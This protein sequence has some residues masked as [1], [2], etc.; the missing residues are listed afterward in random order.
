[1]KARALTG[2]PPPGR[3]RARAWL[4]W[5]LALLALAYLVLMVVTGA[6]PRQRQLVEF[7][8]R[9][10]M[11]EPPESIVRVEVRCAGEQSV[12]VRGQ[13]GWKLQGRGPLAADAGRR[14]SMAVQF[15]N[16]S[17]PLRHLAS[18]ELAGLTP[19]AFGL[20]SPVVAAT[21]HD[22]RGPLLS[23]SFGAENPEGTAQY[24]SIEGRDGV[25]LISRF[26]ASEW[27]AVA[28]LA[29]GQ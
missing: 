15:L 3:P 7:E 14:V 19:A 4:A 16:T 27:A 10:V 9:G 29:A 26:V 28:A 8:A 20:D 25:Y 23:V 11:Q 5:A 21:V 13:A 6:L 22:A 17:A 24:M 2:A 18:S 1:M 12:F